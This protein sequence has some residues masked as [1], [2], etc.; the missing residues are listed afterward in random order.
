MTLRGAWQAAAGVSEEA[1]LGAGGAGLVTA[2]AVVALAVGLLE[3]GTSTPS[4]DRFRD[5]LRGLT[6]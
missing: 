6:S 5:P 2:V 1:V 3:K 4:G